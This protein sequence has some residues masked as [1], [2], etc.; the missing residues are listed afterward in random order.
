MKALRDGLVHYSDMRGEPALRT[1][2]QAKL[3]DYNK[4]T[5]SPDEILM[6]NGLTQLLSWPSCAAR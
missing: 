4:I 1:A 2:L 5:V 3:R 6:T